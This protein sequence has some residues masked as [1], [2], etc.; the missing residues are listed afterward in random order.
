MRNRGLT[1][2][3]ESCGGIIHRIKTVEEDSPTIRTAKLKKEQVKDIE[4]YARVHEFK[5]VILFGAEN[6]V[7]VGSGP[8]PVPKADLSITNYFIGSLK[9]ITYHPP[10]SP[11]VRVYCPVCSATARW[12]RSDRSSEANLF[13]RYCQLQF[14]AETIDNIPLANVLLNK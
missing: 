7:K 9:S 13:C 11:I 8:K 3:R 12:Q 10:A 2:K 4:Y 6:R 14:R 1:T 5:E